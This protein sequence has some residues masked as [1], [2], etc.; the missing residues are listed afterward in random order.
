MRKI[1]NFSATLGRPSEEE[2][3]RRKYIRGLQQQQLQMQQQQEQQMQLQQQQMQQNSDR[4]TLKSLKRKD[5]IKRSKKSSYLLPDEQELQVEPLFRGYEPQQQQQQQQHVRMFNEQPVNLVQNGFAASGPKRYTEQVKFRDKKSKKNWRQSQI[6]DGGAISFDSEEIN[7]GSL[8][9]VKMRSKS[10]N[11]RRS[12][13]WRQSEYLDHGSQTLVNNRERKWNN[14]RF[15]MAVDIDD[16]VLDFPPE[17]STFHQSTMNLKDAAGM[18]HRNSHLLSQRERNR[19]KSTQ[20]LNYS[21]HAADHSSSSLTLGHHP[22]DNFMSASTHK[23]RFLDHPKPSDQE[24]PSSSPGRG[25]DE[26]E[27]WALAAA[28]N[29]K[30]TRLDMRGDSARFSGSSSGKLLVDSSNNN[31]GNTTMNNMSSSELSSSSGLEMMMMNGATKQMAKK[32]NNIDLN[33]NNSN[34]NTAGRKKRTTNIGN[35]SSSS[36]KQQNGS[37]SNSGNSSKDD[38]FENYR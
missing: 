10:A 31:S 12:D 23:L 4:N 33:N 6:L 8:P 15:T 35:S 30:A 38:E 11:Q 29:D 34:T 19:S 27:M 28:A 24:H 5:K 18:N 1:W 2:R 17:P 20:F 7:T 9:K 16:A 14:R 32:L 3:E 36:K 37:N 21:D 13:H 22:R 25:V 26:D